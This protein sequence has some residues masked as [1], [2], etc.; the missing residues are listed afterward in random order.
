MDAGQGE[1]AELTPTIALL[2]KVIAQSEDMEAGTSAPGETSEQGETTAEQA[3]SIRPGGEDEQAEILGPYIEPDLELA[4]HTGSRETTAQPPTTPPFD[5]ALL[6]DDTIVVFVDDRTV[7]SSL[8]HRPSQVV[9]QAADDDPKQKRKRATSDSL[10][11]TSVRASKRP[12]MELNA[13]PVK[14][15]IVEEIEARPEE[16]NKRARAA[17]AELTAAVTSKRPRIEP[18]PGQNEAF[19]DAAP[20]AVNTRANQRS[21]K[22]A[23]TKKAAPPPLPLAPQGPQPA[24][25]TTR[26]RA[27]RADDISPKTIPRPP[28]LPTPQQVPPVPPPKKRGRKPKPDPINKPPTA[29]LTWAMVEPLLPSSTFG[30]GASIHNRRHWTLKDELALR[31]AWSDADEARVRSTTTEAE[32]ACG[33]AIPRLYNCQLQDL[34]RYGLKYIHHKPVKAGA[35][36]NVPADQHFWARLYRLLPHPFFQGN[37]AVLRY[38]LQQAVCARFGDFDKHTIPMVPPWSHSEPEFITHLKELRE[39]YPVKSMGYRIR[40]HELRATAA[41]RCLTQIMGK[42]G[43]WELEAKMKNE[44]KYTYK[45]HL[46]PPAVPA[47]ELEKYLFLIQERDLVFLEHCLDELDKQQRHTQEKEAGEWRGTS[48]HDSSR[49]SSWSEELAGGEMPLGVPGAGASL[50]MLHAPPRS[51]NVP[52]ESITVANSFNKFLDGMSEDEKSV[53]NEQRQMYLAEKRMAILAARREG[54]VRKR[55]GLKNGG[56][57]LD[58]PPFDPDPDFQNFP[59]DPEGLVFTQD[60]FLVV[61]GVYNVPDVQEWLYRHGVGEEKHPNI[62]TPVS[63]MQRVFDAVE[64]MSGQQD[65]PAP[66]QSMHQDVARPAGSGVGHAADGDTVRRGPGSLRLNAITRSSV[67]NQHASYQQR[68]QAP[69]VPVLMMGGGL[70]ARRKGKPKGLTG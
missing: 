45:G 10:A 64:G 56:V 39:R 7:A 23:R 8:D 30:T 41:F 62:E 46:N 53:T 18:P 16:G 43:M 68:G 60:G 34:F 13:Q 15:D 3:P 44:A 40:S 51:K 22:R 49:D 31:N 1:P 42:N 5:T 12:R 2:L 58:V 63:A 33:V 70:W 61:M 27:L 48:G 59:P 67:V 24:P 26:S 69:A 20:D 65:G 32:F 11:D 47:A 37:I 25:R 52:L 6:D 29:H 9:D 54:L 66:E 50:A 17:S 35:R 4:V 36:G 38:T 28:P 57:L 19:L 21:I 55:L 14:D